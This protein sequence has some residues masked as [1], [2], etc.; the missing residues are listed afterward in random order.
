MTLD[1]FML[2][3]FGAAFFDRF[4]YFYL[5]VP[6]YALYKLLEL[7]IIPW[8]KTAFSGDSG[9]QDGDMD[10]ASRKKLERTEKRAQK[11]AQKWR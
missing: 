9:Q 3:Q 4:W 2:M 11:R 10:D 6:G 7:V 5:V 8:A 1:L